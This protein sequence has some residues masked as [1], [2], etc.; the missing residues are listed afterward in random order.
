[1]VAQSIERPARAVL[2]V[3]LYF[4]L[5]ALFLN[6]DIDDGFVGD[7]IGYMGPNTA[8]FAAHPWRPFVEPA[9]VNDS[10]HPLVVA[11]LVGLFWRFFPHE[12]VFAHLAIWICGAVSLAATH[13]LAAHVIGTNGV[14][15]RAA[16]GALAA[17]LLFVHP[18]FLAM[19]T[20]YLNA[21]PSLAFLTSM[22]LA[23]SQNRLVAVAIWGLLLTFTRISGIMAV[24]GLAAFVVYRLYRAGASARSPRTVAALAPYG[25]CAALLGAYLVVKLGLLGLPL[26]TFD[27]HYQWNPRPGALFAGL[28]DVGSAAFFSPAGGI[29]V[30]FLFAI[31]AAAAALLR[32]WNAP[33][34][35]ER[36][37]SA[38]WDA[39][40]CYGAMAAIFAVEGAFEALHG[41]PSQ[42][43]WFLKFYPFAIVAGLHGLLVLT[44]ERRALWLP[45]AVAWAALQI[46][47]WE[48]HWLDPLA[49]YAPALRAHLALEGQDESLAVR[50]QVRSY[51][52]LV[53]DTAAIQPAPLVV[54][55]YPT[56][57]VLVRAPAGYVREPFDHI[58]LYGILTPQ[59]LCRALAE[60]ATPD[61]TPVHVMIGSWDVLE[62]DRQ[63]IRSWDSLRLIKTY[64][65]GMGHWA[66]VYGLD[67]STCS[68][69]P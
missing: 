19:T 17:G 36:G 7:A 21:V 4:A 53:E 42:S 35:R 1:V 47:R 40:S 61:D 30:W 2:L 58:Y 22:V 59:Q 25:A 37:P 65:S 69:Q 8:E 51:E 52:Q 28:V 41:L 67:R 63:T 5:I 14:G 23:A 16:T 50:R 29:F 11:Y 26:T 3:A 10:G 68:R 43:R 56:M 60:G 12:P 66:D 49:R 44:R 9:P 62:L 18:M 54:G 64:D 38:T 20:Q 45:V 15:P 57:T 33:V 24:A 13:R 31:A 34:S 46:L 48:E 27:A 39:R 32:P 6:R 55:Y